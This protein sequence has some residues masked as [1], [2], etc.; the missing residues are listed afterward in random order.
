MPIASSRRSLNQATYAPIS[1][2]DPPVAVRAWTKWNYFTSLAAMVGDFSDIRANILH[3]SATSDNPNERRVATRALDEL[4][5]LEGI[6]PRLRTPDALSS[7]STFQEISPETLTLLGETYLQL[8]E[9]HAE[10]LLDAEREIRES[11]VV[12][13]GSEPKFSTP[14][15]LLG[16]E[17][18]EGSPTHAPDLRIYRRVRRSDD[19]GVSS[20]GEKLAD[21]AGPESSE[22]TAAANREMR[23]GTVVLDEV[24]AL[25]GADVQV[26]ERAGRE[27]PCLLR[28]VATWAI[29][30][31][32]RAPEASE[33]LRLA[34]SVEAASTPLDTKRALMMHLND[35]YQLVQGFARNMSVEPIGLLHLER[36]NFSPVGMERGE[37][38]HSVPLAPGE[39]ANIA[40]REW[41]NTSEEFE[42]LATDY[43]DTY[44]EKGVVE[45]SELSE[46]TSHQT[47]HSTAYNTGVTVSGGYGPV[48][49]SSSFSYNVNSSA[50]DSS[51]ASLKRTQE[52]TSKAS[53]RVTQEH[54]ISF[55]TASAAGTEDQT[56]QKLKNP[57]QTSPTRLDYYQLIRKWRVDLERYGLRLTYDITI[58]EPGSDILPQTLEIEQ[59]EKRINE[60]FVFD[61]TPAEITRDNY[62]QMAAEYLTTV[63]DP[64]DPTVTYPTHKE[65]YFADDGAT[66]KWRF[67]SLD[68]DVDSRYR[69]TGVS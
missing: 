52:A 42:K 58:P 12:W 57:D 8:A 45:K 59:L 64:P 66:D 46:A 29:G 33:L 26:Q 38:V 65:D 56:V 2:K 4:T 68:F 48:N 35:A 23:T 28:D 22:E 5:I 51:Q 25:A 6:V 60:E 37:L 14:S 3:R 63:D 62:L 50:S 19:S 24:V 43:M 41:S 55:R 31:K 18:V 7:V 9:Q 49:V 21:S 36:V 34:A 32:I 11:F 27:P 10:A 69:I 44:S 47:Q 39:E 15:Q 1:I 20:P 30:H 13:V 53:S 17:L 16:F 40:H 54:R 61:R 67:A